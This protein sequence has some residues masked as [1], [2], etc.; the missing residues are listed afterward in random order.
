MSNLYELNDDFRELSAAIESGE[1][2]PEDAA[3]TLDGMNIEFEAKAESIGFVCRNMDGDI[4]AI[5]AEVERL[6]SRKKKLEADQSGL[7]DYL[8]NAMKVR[9]VK[10]VKTS[11][12]TFSY[13]KPT[14][15]AVID[16]EAAILAQ[17]FVTVPAV[18]ERS[19]L[20]KRLL[21]KGLKEGDIMGA[22]LEDGKVSL[23]IK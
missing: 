2:S 4:N 13:R 22:H 11:L 6:L 19:K 23:T 18:P 8:L 20:D 16:D 12:F 9:E 1:L 14:Q 10:S 17:Y 21:L 3:D 15:V 5:S 7:K